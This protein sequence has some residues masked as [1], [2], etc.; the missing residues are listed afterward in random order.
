MGIYFRSEL[1]E[2]TEAPEKDAE[3]AEKRARTELILLKLI[4]RSCSRSQPLA[5]PNPKL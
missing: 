1:L 3:H 5:S 2:D 4:L